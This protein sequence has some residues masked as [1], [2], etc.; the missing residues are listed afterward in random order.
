MISLLLDFFALEIALG[1]RKCVYAVCVCVGGCLSSQD[2]LS[3]F[4]E[5]RIGARRYLG[6]I[7]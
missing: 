1:T 4:S 5:E 7:L 3:H 6:F 2:C